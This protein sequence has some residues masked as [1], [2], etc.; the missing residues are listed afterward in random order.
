MR[1]FMGMNEDL[2]LVGHNFTN[3]ATSLYVATLIT[4]VAMGRLSFTFH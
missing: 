1:L 3:T 4:E 2:K